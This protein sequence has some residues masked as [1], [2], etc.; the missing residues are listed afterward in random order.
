MENR[1]PHAGDP[2]SEGIVEG[3]TVMCRAHGWKFDIRTGFH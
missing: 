2:L 1:C 3:S